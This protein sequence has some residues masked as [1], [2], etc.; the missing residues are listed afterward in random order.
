MMFEWWDKMD[1][2]ILTLPQYLK[3]DA[4]MTL[5][6]FQDLFDSGAEYYFIAVPR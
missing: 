1:Y 2:E 4:G 6:N 3:G 5:M